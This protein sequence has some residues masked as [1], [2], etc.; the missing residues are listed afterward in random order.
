MPVQHLADNSI[1]VSDPNQPTF[2]RGIKQIDVSKYVVALL[3][4][5]DDFSPTEISLASVLCG[6]HHVS[7]VSNRAKILNALVD[8]IRLHF[9]QGHYV[10]IRGWKPAFD[11]AWDDAAVEAFKGTLQQ[12]VEYQG[13][14]CVC[15]LQQCYT[16]QMYLDSAKRVQAV[17][18][19]RND[20][21]ARAF[22]S[23][24]EFLRLGR[25]SPETCGNLLDSTATHTEYPP[26]IP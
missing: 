11:T 26:F 6:D 21:G 14:L 20:T 16:Y 10:I 17:D 4:N 9:A 25:E 7:C 1:D 13:E 8:T 5:P 2:P 23:L 22:S 12:P 24:A 18:S 15:V 19:T 3:Y